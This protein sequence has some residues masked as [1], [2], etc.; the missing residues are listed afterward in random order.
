MLEDTEAKY[1]IGVKL[2]GG[3]SRV[4]ILFTILVT[5]LL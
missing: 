3:P 5:F 2:F 4:A 1:D